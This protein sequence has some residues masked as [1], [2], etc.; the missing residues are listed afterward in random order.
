M[1]ILSG[2]EYALEYR[3][4]DKDTGNVVNDSVKVKVHV[5]IET[6]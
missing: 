1:K 3:I 2:T 4:V 6:E 5:K